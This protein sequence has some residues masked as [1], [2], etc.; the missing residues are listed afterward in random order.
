M[1]YFFLK[2]STFFVVQGITSTE[3]FSCGEDQLILVYFS[4]L[5]SYLGNTSEN[6]IFNIIGLNMS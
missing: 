2:M 1:R 5:T 6:D 3:A 4:T